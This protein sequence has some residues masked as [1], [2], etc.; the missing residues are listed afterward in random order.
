MKKITI[1]STVTLITLLALPLQGFSESRE[2]FLI[3]VST[4]AGQGQKQGQ[5]II[6]TI[7]EF[8]IF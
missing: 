1:I 6:G 5:G 2:V 3:L 8:I 7:K 4:E